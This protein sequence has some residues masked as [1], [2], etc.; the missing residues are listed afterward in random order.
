[1]QP[2]AHSFLYV[3]CDIPA[4]ITVLEWRR[5][6]VKPRRRLAALRRKPVD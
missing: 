2:Q 6:N 3:E 4:G 1:M 5:L